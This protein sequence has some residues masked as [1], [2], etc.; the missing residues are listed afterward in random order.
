[1][2]KGRYWNFK[3]K[4]LSLAGGVATEEEAMKLVEDRLHNECFVR[5]F[6]PFLCR[7]PLQETMHKGS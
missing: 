1:M 2:E 5:S 3:E 7:S 6:S 4:A